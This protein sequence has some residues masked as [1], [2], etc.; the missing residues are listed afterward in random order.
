MGELYNVERWRRLARRR[1]PKVVFDF[2]DGGADDEVTL[3]R[4]RAA[5][6]DLC[7][8]PR[9]LRGVDEVSTQVELFGQSLR[10]PVL[11]APTGG[12]RMASPLGEVA[13]AKGASAAGTLS[14]LSSFAS[15]APDEVAASVPE[16]HWFQLYLF[17]DRTRTEQLLERVKRLG[18]SALVLT[19][20]A[21]VAGNRERD[22]RNGFTIPVRITPRMA[23][24][25]LIRPQWAWHYLVGGPIATHV[26]TDQQ[27]ADEGRLELKELAEYVH[28]MM[29]PQQ[30]WDD[31]SWLRAAWDGPLLLK[32]V[33]CRADAELAV[34]AGCDGVIVSNH[35]GR[36]LDSVAAGIEVLPEVVAA[37]RGRA[38][39]LVDGGF[40]RGTDVVKALSLGAKAC[41]IGR[42]WLFSLAAA[43]EGGVTRMLDQL[44]S[45]IART[46]QLLGVSKLAELGPDY[47]R[48]RAGRAWEAVDG[49][50][51]PAVPGQETAP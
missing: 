14:I 34:D 5:F 47:V 31:L 8:V 49:G 38:E 33:M 27:G 24:G 35:G 28:A 2:I 48:R 46:L 15:V 29:N 1:L 43:G 11:L 51:P 44:R 12:G 22:T 26:D 19:A 45:E 17:R 36:Q 30:T 16:P 9:V 39:V 32:G 18:F 37:V 6:E 25:A 40:R 7:L 10:V 3:R 21:P 42:P 50:P 23:F 13:Q 20:D 41:L 4:N